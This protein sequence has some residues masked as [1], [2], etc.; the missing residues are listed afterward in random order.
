M[1]CLTWQPTLGDNR[2]GHLSHIILLIT[3]SALPSH[4]Q[5]FGITQQ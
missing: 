4:L 2:V 5:P 1:M 3:V